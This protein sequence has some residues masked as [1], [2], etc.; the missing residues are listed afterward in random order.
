MN[1]D[2]NHDNVIKWKH[3]P[4]YWSFVRGIQR[5]FPRTVT[6]SFDVFFDLRLNKRLSKQSRGWWFETPTC[7]LWRHCT[8]SR[9]YILLVAALHICCWFWFYVIKS[10]LHQ[11]EFWNTGISNAFKMRHLRMGVLCCQHFHLNSIVAWNKN[12]TA[13]FI[14]TYFTFWSL[15]W[16]IKWKDFVPVV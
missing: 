13:V 11:K 2:V 4:C 3:F 8:V 7:Q 9:K 1:N 5:S 16:I 6:R 15:W 14:C 12:K 10:M